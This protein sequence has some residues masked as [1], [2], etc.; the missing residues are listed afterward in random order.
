MRVCVDCGGGGGISVPHPLED[1]SPGL[2][3]HSGLG[4]ILQSPPPSLRPVDED[5]V[6]HALC[7]HSITLTF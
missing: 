2:P 3:S 7:H 1:F 6:P 5:L 4:I